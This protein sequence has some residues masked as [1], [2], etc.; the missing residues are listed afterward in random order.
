MPFLF[1]D[2]PSIPRFDLTTAYFNDC[3]RDLA[4]KHDVDLVIEMPSHFDGCIYRL[5]KN[6]ETSTFQIRS[7]ELVQNDDVEHIKNMA[8]CRFK[9][10][11]AT[12]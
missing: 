2:I 1:E 11:M 6:G 9:T 3:V 12:L 7:L 5:T 8:E 4:I 10:G